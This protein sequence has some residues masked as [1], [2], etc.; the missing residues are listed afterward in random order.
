MF[1]GDYS[2]MVSNIGDYQPDLQK[3]PAGIGAAKGRIEQAGLEIGLHM[4]SSGATVCLD[5]MDKG[6]SPYGR[7]T[8]N[9]ASPDYCTITCGRCRHG[10]KGNRVPQLNPGEDGT[11]NID[12][13]ASN[14]L[15]HLMIPQG[16]TPLS[17]YHANNAGA[18]YQ[19]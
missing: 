1:I 10:C 3:W 9:T 15:H 17:F 2:A 14:S 11:A 6:W 4:I 16:P 12:T 7:C 13:V 18:S 19:R 8:D 5:Q